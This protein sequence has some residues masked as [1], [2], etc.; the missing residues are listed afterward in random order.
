M[1]VRASRGRYGFVNR[2]L[3]SRLVKSESLAA[4]GIL[5]RTAQFERKADPSRGARNDAR[6]GIQKPEFRSQNAGARFA[7]TT[8]ICNRFLRAR[9]V[10]GFCRRVGFFGSRVGKADP[11]RGARDDARRGIQ[12]PEFRSQK[13][14]GRCALRAVDTDCKPLPPGAARS[15][16]LYAEREPVRASRG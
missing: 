13:P 3:R 15:H 12:K 2:S 7:R 6:R 10:P 14:E 4:L 9:L 16:P 8:Q 1:P 11:S 5:K